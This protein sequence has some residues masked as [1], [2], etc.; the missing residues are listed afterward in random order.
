MAK[1]RQKNPGTV[2]TPEEDRGHE[3]YTMDFYV[4]LDRSA[5]IS[6]HIAGMCS[7]AADSTYVRQAD[8]QLWSALPGKYAPFLHTILSETKGQFVPPRRS[9]RE[10]RKW[11]EYLCHKYKS[12]Y[13]PFEFYRGDLQSGPVL[14]KYCSRCSTRCKKSDCDLSRTGNGCVVRLIRNPWNYLWSFEPD[15]LWTICR[16]GT[17]TFLYPTDHSYGPSSRMKLVIHF[18]WH[19]R[20]FTGAY[21]GLQEP[22]T[23]CSSAMLRWSEGTYDGLQEFRSVCQGLNVCIYFLEASSTNFEG[24]SFYV[25]LWKCRRIFQT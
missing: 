4:L 9:R 16:P 3:N 11:R 15:R 5:V 6:K 2:R 17:T 10:M 14:I 1:L 7:E 8:I 23:V 20:R 22:T 13:F 21:N 24:F 25:R 19:L 12:F 18:L